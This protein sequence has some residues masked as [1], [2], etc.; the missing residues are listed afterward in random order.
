V[1]KLI[2][3]QDGWRRSPFFVNRSLGIGKAVSK[4]EYVHEKPD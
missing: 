4:L 1:S 3:I 2:L